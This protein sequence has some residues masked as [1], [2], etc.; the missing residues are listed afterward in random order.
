MKKIL[1]QILSVKPEYL[2]SYDMSFVN[3]FNLF[4]DASCCSA[5]PG[6]EHY[7]LLVFIS[8]LYNNSTL[9]DVGTNACRSALCIAVN[10]SN[11]VKSYDIIKVEPKDPVAPN[12]EFILGD[13]TKDPD[14]KNSPFI[15]LDVDHDGSYENIFY[16]HL[17]NTNWKGL[18]FLDDI[19]LN[20]AMKNFWNN[21]TQEKHDITHLGHWS[22]T[23]IVVFN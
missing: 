16:K 3:K 19:Y 5:Q 17:C 13:S 12:I 7:R 22:G 15:M 23:G 2:S 14:L 18:L 11:K 1:E 10:L 21:I 9:F 4:H 6:R 20:E 8:N